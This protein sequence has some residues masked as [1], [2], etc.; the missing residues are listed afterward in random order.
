M[1]KSRSVVFACF[2]PLHSLQGGAGGWIA[3]HRSSLIVRRYETIDRRFRLEKIRSR[4]KVACLQLN[5]V[6][7]SRRS[8]IYPSD[9][10][11]GQKVT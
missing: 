4:V 8:N 7:P 9:C 10:M 6:L 1:L 5:R 3:A 11:V 2:R